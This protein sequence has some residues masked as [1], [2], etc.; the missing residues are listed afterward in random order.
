ME[1][2]Y[3]ESLILSGEYQNILKAMKVLDNLDVEGKH[4]KFPAIFLLLGKAFVR[5]N[6]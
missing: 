2:L 3:S 5:L 4:N 1:F 6:R